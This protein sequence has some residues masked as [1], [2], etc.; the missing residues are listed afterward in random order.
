[1]SY[2]SLPVLMTRFIPLCLAALLCLSVSAAHGQTLPL[3]TAADVMRVKPGDAGRGDLPVKLKGVIVSMGPVPQRLSVHD[4]RA[5]VIVMAPVPMPHLR[6]G[7]SVEVEGMVSSWQAGPRTNRMIAAKTI[8]PGAIGPLPKAKSIG[9]SALNAF[10]ELDQWVSVEGHLVSWRRK[11]PFF[12]LTIVSTEIASTV[13]VWI[14]DHQQL[15]ANFHGA[16]LRLTGINTFTNHLG[17]SLGVTNLDQMEVLE[18]GTLD[19]FEAPLVSIA[20]LNAR[21]VQQARRLRVRGTLITV[22]ESRSLIVQD[23]AGDATALQLAEPRAPGAA[24]AIYGDGGPLP[25][26]QSGDVIEVVGSVIDQPTHA[27]KTWGM[28]LCHVRMV[29]KGKV[30]EP[31]KV[32]LDTFLAYR[33]EGHWVTFDAV[34][35]AWMLQSNGMTYAVG[36]DRTWTT[37]SVRSPKLDEFPKDL[38]G[39]RLRF[40]GLSTGLALNFRGA[41]MIVPSPFFVEVVKLGTESPF[42]APEHKAADIASG[43]IPKGELVKTKGVLVGEERSVLYVRGADASM[44]ISL[45]QPWARLGNPPGIAFADGGPLPS[46]KIGDE[47]EVA[48]QQF[49]TE[50]YASFD[51]ADASVRVTG[52]QDNVA[53]VETTFARI[54]AGEHTSDLVKV[55]GRLLTLQVAPIEGGKWRTT[56]LLTSGGHRITAVHQS[57]VLHP[58]DTLKKDDDLILQAAV[59][60]ATPSSPRQ[61]WLFSPGDVKSLGV[62]PE[63]IARRIWIWGGL[64]VLGIGILG[65]WVLLLRRS[66]RRQARA[67]AELKAASDAARESEQR[68]KLLFEQSPLSVQIFSPDGQAKRFNQ[69]WKNLF[70]LND[71]Q[72]FA[73]NVLKD[74]DLNASGAVHLIRKAF[75]GEVV[76]VPPV[77]FPVNT[78]PPEHRWIGGVLY[79]V[80]NDDGE[81]ME[82]VTIHNDITEMKR[83]EEAMLTLN[84]TLERSVDERTAELRETQAQLSLALDQERE[85]SELKSRFVSMVSHEFR[86]PLGIIMSAIEL[87]RHYDDRLPQEK[88]KE[89]Q[90]DVFSATRHMADLMEQVL[91]LGRVEAGKMA[92]KTAPC[93]LDVLAGKLTDESLSAT[94]RKCPVIWRAENDL[95]GANADEAL[96]RHIFSNLITNAVKYS[97]AGSEVQFTARRD[98]SDAVFTI[99]DH[100]IGI[101]EGDRARLFEAFHRCSNVGD[102]PGTGLGLV[103][104]KRCVELHGGSLDIDSVVGQ[105]TTFTIRLPLFD[106]LHLPRT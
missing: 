80:K 48:G 75:E 73:F 40:T 43:H 9:L 10:E 100:G 28:V 55:R 77:P 72:G 98:G 37:I 29:G 81:I 99:I 35:H 104:V 20:D 38:F 50:R 101:P 79:P 106:A 82:V 39:A 56:M 11:S 7:Q 70:R 44:C 24:D 15:P 8:V 84:Q 33:D 91:V 74:P 102:I 26:L 2:A 67:A 65:G 34:V 68:W 31:E 47:V 76:H 64:A 87:M 30:P 17:E 96:L 105:G 93:D 3:T 88:R 23:E 53:S 21:K 69:A 27:M 51:L 18:P 103:I 5:T 90:Q 19:V 85:L 83:A 78:D 25:P 42:D 4:G 49:T 59:D 89:L 61:L 22:M 16:R 86:T 1:M 14:G 62:S 45:L 32:S 57:T 58:F 13:T 63:I 94:N 36:D 54:V 41:Q 92:C 97:A 12:T 6:M 95:S 46:L 52:H 66:Q 60:R 71:E